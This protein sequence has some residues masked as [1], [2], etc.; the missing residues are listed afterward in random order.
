MYPSMQSAHTS[1]WHALSSHA[2]FLE[3]LQSAARGVVRP[4]GE[5]GGGRGLTFP[6]GT[7]RQK[8]LVH[9]L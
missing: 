2:L 4:M 9:R 8:V 1:A 5:G 3:T 7:A 6:I